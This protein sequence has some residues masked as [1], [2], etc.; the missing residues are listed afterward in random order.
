MPAKGISCEVIETVWLTQTVV[1]IRF[2]PQKKFTYDAGQFLSIYVPHPDGHSRPLRRPYSFNC[3]PE[4][5]KKEGYELCVKVVQNG[6]GSNYL[7][8]MKPGSTFMATAPYGDFLFI[9]RPGR[10]ACFICTGTGVAPI[11]AILESKFFQANRPERVIILFGARTEDEIIY[12]GLFE[13]LGIHTV[14]C[15]SDPQ[16]SNKL[17]YRGRVTDYLRNAPKNFEWHATDYYICG[18][19]QMIDEVYRILFHE[20]GVEAAAISKEAYF[21]SHAVGLAPIR[22]AKEEEE[23]A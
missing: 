21:E 16:D 15:I 17:H 22:S 19:G 14:N 6:V 4:V 18:N 1:M 13:S 2:Q 5:A 11:K 10:V 7:A 20:R 8:Q 3:P 12:P 23:A 9:P